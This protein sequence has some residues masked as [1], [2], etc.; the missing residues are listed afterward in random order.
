MSIEKQRPIRIN[1]NPMA[2]TIK[3]SGP[4]IPQNDPFKQTY[5]KGSHEATDVWNKSKPERNALSAVLI[6][7]VIDLAISRKE[8]YPPYG[9]LNTQ[10]KIAESLQSGSDPF[11]ALENYMGATLRK[12]LMDKIKDWNK[13]TNISRFKP[14]I[15]AYSQPIL[16]AY[17]RY[18]MILDFKNKYIGRSRYDPK[19]TVKLALNRGI[20]TSSEQMSALLKVIPE[21]YSQEYPDQQPDTSELISIAK[22]SYYFIVGLASDHVEVFSEKK[23]VLGTGGGPFVFSPRYRFKPEYF[24]II[25]TVNGPTISLKESAKRFIEEFHENLPKDYKGGSEATGCPALV[26]FRANGKPSG[27]AIKKLWDWHVELGEEIYKGMFQGKT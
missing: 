17:K 14:P 26:D 9:L 27:S 23:H 3:E 13:V 7:E 10:G 4:E 6:D 8:L 5:Q 16:E 18:K 21:V 11:R 15:Q 20:G 1:I 25:Q 19:E 2:R 22:N 12:A 24:G